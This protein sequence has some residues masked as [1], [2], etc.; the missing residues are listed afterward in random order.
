MNFNQLNSDQ[1]HPYYQ[2]YLDLLEPDT[3]L[4]PSLKAQKNQV[5]DF[6]KAIPEDMHTHAYQEG[7]W[8]IN[9]VLQHI[10]DTERIFMYR[11]LRIARG[12]T[13][14]LMGFEQDEYI[15][16][17]G[18]NKKSMEQLINEYDATRAYS[19]SLIASLAIDNLNFIGEASNSPLSAGAAGFITLAHERWHIK[20]IEERYL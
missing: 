15:V 11:A 6:F 8:T 20:I 14:P 5:T 13:S 1:Y 3:A 16:P 19:I 12:D 10:I 18:A 2:I 7:K 4:V 9:E 17:S